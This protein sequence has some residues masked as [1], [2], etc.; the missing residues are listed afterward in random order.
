MR[1]E[2][3]LG[4]A[5]RPAAGLYRDHA[6]KPFKRKP[7]GRICAWYGCTTILSTYNPDPEC[8]IHTSPD[9][10]HRGWEWRRKSA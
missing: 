4:L 7:K 5:A 1:E 9:Y 8:F 6:H 2:R 3:I 10:R